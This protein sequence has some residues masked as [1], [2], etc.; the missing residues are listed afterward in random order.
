M[1]SSTI[2]LIGGI[3]GGALGLAGGIFGTYISYKKATSTQSKSLIIKGTI[4]FLVFVSLFLVCRF[5]L[6]P[7]YN[8]Y[9]FIPYIIVLASA[10]Y[11]LNK[12]LHKNNPRNEV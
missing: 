8:D 5:T 7:P 12:N 9:I 1:D 4:F 6:A 10:I 2:G 11:Y 3:I